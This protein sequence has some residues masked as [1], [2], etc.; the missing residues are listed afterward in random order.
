VTKSIVANVVNVNKTFPLLLAGL[1]S[2]EFNGVSAA[3]FVSPHQG[4]G[5]VFGNDN[6]KI[7]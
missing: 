4:M 1:V 7:A 3:E 5:S 6:A 2:F